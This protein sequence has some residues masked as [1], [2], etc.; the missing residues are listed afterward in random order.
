VTIRGAAWSGK[1]IARVEV[2]TNAGTTWRDAELLGESSPGAWRLWQLDWQT[3]AEPGELQ[4]LAR[5]TDTVG[6]GQ[7]S[8]RDPD[9]GTYMIN[10]L[11][12]VTVTVA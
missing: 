3:P 8:E 7:P 5:A 9:R 12:P 2:S 11:V 10:H 4:L 6:Q 1:D